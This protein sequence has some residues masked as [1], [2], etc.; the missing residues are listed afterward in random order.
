L[1]I[2]NGEPVVLGKESKL[3]KCIALMRSERKRLEKEG[4]RKEKW[5]DSRVRIETENNFPT[6]A[7][8]ASSASGFACLVYTLAKLYE[9]EWDTT[10]LSVMA[11]Q[12]SGSACRSLFGGFVKWEMGKLEDGS[13]SVAVQ[14][15]PSTH[16]P[17]LVA[18][19]LVVNDA[20]KDVGSTEG[21]QLTVAS[22]TLFKARIAS[23]VPERMEQ[24][25][26][27]ILSKDF[28]TFGTLTMQDSNQ[29]HAVCLDS[30][31]PIVYMT[32]VSR[33]IVKTVHEWN[34]KSG[35]LRAAYTFDA[36][37]NA[38][39]Y[40]ERESVAE[41]LSVVESVLPRSREQSEDVNYVSDPC[42]VLQAPCVEEVASVGLASA[43][44]GLLKRI[45]V[46]PIGDGPRVVSE[47]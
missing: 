20:K 47:E 17:S 41:W 26:Q 35:R 37:P 6:A 11:R 21:M 42:G 30:Y 24:M 38:V 22:S 34:A 18:V 32:D 9:L 23:V 45:L 44:P 31:P 15:A 33:C 29:F 43:S 2:L 40:L 25:E 14:V 28:E 7:G 12:G 27:A 10:Q 46:V 39:V 3:A 5:A 13:D 1:L 16:W 19:I 36:G 4:K 8:L